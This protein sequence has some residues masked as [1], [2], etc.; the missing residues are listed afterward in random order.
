MDVFDK[1]GEKMKFY[2]CPIE[3]FDKPAENDITEAINNHAK[4]T[5]EAIDNLVL[6]AVH[7]V[8]IKV[9]KD[10]LAKALAYDRGQY[11]KGF[12]DAT[13]IVLCTECKYRDDCEQE[14]LLA[15]MFGEIEESAPIRFCSYGEREEEE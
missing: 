5:A 1:W 15:E 11:E 2:K 10:E 3:M 14:V 9:D 12:A 8:G 6:T 13:N 7:N 4:R